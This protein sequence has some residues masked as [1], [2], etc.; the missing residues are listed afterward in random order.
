MVAPTIA[1][2]R[3]PQDLKAD[4]AAPLMCAGITTFN[5]LRRSG[6][7]GGDIVVV[8]GLGGLGHLGAQFAAKLGFYTVVVSRGADKEALAKKL[9]AH[10]F[11]DA[12]K[13]DSVKEIQALGG[14]KV[15][16]ATAPNAKSIQD[17]IPALGLEGKLLIVSILSEP[18]QLNTNQLLAKNQ[19]IQVWASGDARDIQDTVAFASASGVKSM[20]EV[21]P[22]DK[23]EEAFQHM[24]TNKA[25]FRAVLKISE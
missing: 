2:A 9:G 3:I 19:S 7:I 17:I 18:I 16:L 15:I 21:F 8:Q 4:E 13:Q 10:K 22:L 20:I 14:A 1:L 12:E 24:L 11:I 23:A 6:A 5:A 25:R